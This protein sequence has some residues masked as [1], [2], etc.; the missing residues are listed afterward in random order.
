M[1]GMVGPERVREEVL[2]ERVNVR[3]GCESIFLG[4]LFS[5]FFLFFFWGLYSF[6]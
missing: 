5:F 3:E 2:R 6:I 1:A 4:S